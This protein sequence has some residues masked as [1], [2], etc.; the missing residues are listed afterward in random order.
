MTNDYR[1]ILDQD[2]LDQ[3]NDVTGGDDEF[4]AELVETFLDDAPNLISDMKTGLDA[5]DAREVR[6]LSH[7]LK[8]N[9]TDFGATRLSSLCFTLEHQAAD[10]I[11][12][13]AE[14]L[15][16]EIEAEFAVVKDALE[17]FINS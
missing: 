8:G 9:A 5:E 6:R 3:L 11:L 14:S 4:L 2:A 13:E 1:N 15:I 12:D 10:G 7:G 16:A 17:A